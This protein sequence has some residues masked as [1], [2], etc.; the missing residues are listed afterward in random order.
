MRVMI[1]CGT[2]ILVTYYFFGIFGNKGHSMG[3]AFD[4]KLAENGRLVLPKMV[5]EALGVAGGGTVVFSV[6]D[7]E[8]RLT[9]IQQSIRQAQAL[10]RQH[11]TRNLTVDDFLA[12]RRSE[13]AGEDA[14]HAGK[15]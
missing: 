8:V 4:V 15:A 3:K 2:I 10:Y 5:R 1:G 14:A 11:A 7:G 9:S 6:Q 13:A 12:E